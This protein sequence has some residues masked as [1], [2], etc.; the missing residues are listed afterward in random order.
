[1]D[2]YAKII[3]MTRGCMCVHECLRV[4]MVFV[5]A[6][7]CLCVRT[8]VCVYMC[9][10]VFMCMFVC[11]CVFVC[12]HVCQGCVCVL[13]SSLAFYENDLRSLWG[14]ALIL[15]VRKLMSK[16]LPECL[17]LNENVNDEMCASHREP[18]GFWRA[19]CLGWG[20][21]HTDPGNYMRG[22][23]A[24]ADHVRGAGRGPGSLL[25]ACLSVWGTS[26]PSSSC[27][28]KIYS[29]TEFQASLRSRC[30]LPCGKMRPRLDSK[31]L[32]PVSQPLG[33]RGR[34]IWSPRPNSTTQ[35]VWGQPE[36]H[37]I[38]LKKERKCENVQELGLGAQV[39]NPIYSRSWGRRMQDSKC[40]WATDQ[41]Q[42]QPEQLSGTRS[43]IN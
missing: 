18:S 24:L 19:P 1:M 32:V 22:C 41:V 31:R 4:H 38:S 29:T 34:K 2:N 15:Q 10:C 28:L 8:C 12:A 11:T 39:F 7:L 40:A 21:N 33:G 42:G 5:C 37:G 20:C 43:I 25:A 26:L 6:H 27:S 14:S 30:F 23:T 3:S 17:G 16:E 35:W 13:V 36:L 9:V